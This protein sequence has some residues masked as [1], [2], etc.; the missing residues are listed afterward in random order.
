MKKEEEEK[1]RKKELHLR[2]TPDRIEE[3]KGMPC[4]S[5]EGPEP[6][7]SN[8]ESRQETIYLSDLVGSAKPIHPGPNWYEC[9]KDCH[10]MSNFDSSYTL[11]SYKKVLENPGNDYP[12]VIKYKGKYYIADGGKHRLTI[13]KIIGVTQ[14]SVIV[15]EIHDIKTDN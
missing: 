8:S 7:S 4:E 12:V 13:G 3:L 11:D 5:Y 10:K 9:L 1:E 2:L 15:K 14:A 6:S